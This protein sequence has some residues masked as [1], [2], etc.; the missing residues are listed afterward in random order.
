MIYIDYWLQFLKN[1]NFK[2]TITSQRRYFNYFLF[3][4]FLSQ[5]FFSSGIFYIKSLFKV[6]C[7]KKHGC[8][9]TLFFVRTSKFCLRLAV[10]N[11]FSFLRLKCSWFVLISPTEPC[12]AIKKH[13]RLSS[14]KALFHFFHSFS[15]KQL[16]KA[17]TGRCLQKSS[18]ETVLKPIKKYCK[19][20][21]FFIKVA[22]FKSATLLKLNS[23]KGIFHRFWTQMQ[24]YTL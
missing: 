4:I 22:C 16:R 21:Q 9:Y 13:V 14:I 24:L 12:N 8:T 6:S 5:G 2:Y 17:A 3:Y 20:V 23:F 10:L 7:T 11:F 15:F 18:S 1:D 19:G